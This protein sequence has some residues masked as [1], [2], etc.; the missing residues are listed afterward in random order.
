[1]TLSEYLDINK[2]S[3]ADFARLIG[4]GSRATIYR[5]LKG[6]RRAPSHDMMRR[7]T[8]ATAGAVTAN[9]FYNIPTNGPAHD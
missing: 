9:D 6:T 7:I 3:K 1:M 2:I 4:A 8:D 5:Y